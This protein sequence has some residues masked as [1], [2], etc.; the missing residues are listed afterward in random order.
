MRC[1][2]HIFNLTPL[3][4]ER[5]E[6]SLL[7]KLGQAVV[8]T[9]DERISSLFRLV[10][11]WLGLNETSTKESLFEMNLLDLARNHLDG[12]MQ[13]GDMLRFLP[14]AFGHLARKFL[15]CPNPADQSLEAFPDAFYLRDRR[16][17]VPRLVLDWSWNL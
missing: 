10:L 8:L 11:D 6:L 9:E 2:L 13:A 1:A 17:P 7:L 15:V 5:G 4:I 14:P 3:D 12:N 16:V